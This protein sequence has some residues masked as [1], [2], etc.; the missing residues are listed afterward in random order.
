MTMYP[1]KRV[2]FA[3]ITPEKQLEIARLGGK[4]AHEQGVAHEYN[5]ETGR[6]AGI[7]GGTISGQR[8]KEKHEISRNAEHV[9]T[10]RE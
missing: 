5:S 8:K 6:K 9:R 4:A 2:G 1:K 10:S 7:K 3:A